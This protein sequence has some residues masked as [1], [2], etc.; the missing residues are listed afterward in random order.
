MK[1]RTAFHRLFMTVFFQYAYYTE[2]QVINY[3]AM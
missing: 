1:N 3:E 2:K